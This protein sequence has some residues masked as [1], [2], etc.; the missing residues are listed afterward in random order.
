M[1]SHLIPKIREF[2]IYS[3]PIC[4]AADHANLHSEVKDGHA[5]SENGQPKHQ[6]TVKTIDVY[7][8]GACNIMLDLDLL[9]FQNQIIQGLSTSLHYATINAFPHITAR[10]RFLQVHGPIE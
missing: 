3:T 8:G 9:A 10:N 2:T 1:R 5:K 7:N 4:L 6:F